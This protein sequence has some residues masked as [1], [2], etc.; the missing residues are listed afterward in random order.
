MM[1]T[2]KE[3]TEIGCAGCSAC[4]DIRFVRDVGVHFA[5]HISTGFMVDL[6]SSFSV[7]F[8]HNAMTLQ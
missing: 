2:E 3:K 8:N 1:R 6:S 4:V 7:S 5:L